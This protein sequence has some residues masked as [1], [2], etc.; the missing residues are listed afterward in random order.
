MGKY[1]IVSPVPSIEVVQI[2]V[3]IGANYSDHLP[4]VGHPLHGGE[5]SGFP[6]KNAQEISG[7]GCIIIE[8]CSKPW[9]VV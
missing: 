8:Q 1:A 2:G 9:L 6:P 3:W 5:K 7:L 4:P